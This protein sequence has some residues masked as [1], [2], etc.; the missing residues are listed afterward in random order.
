MI[1]NIMHWI[2][3]GLYQMIRE[4]K[5]TNW[6]FDHKYDISNKHYLL[7]WKWIS[8]S[9]QLTIIDG[10]FRINEIEQ[11]WKEREREGEKGERVYE[12]SWY[13]KLKF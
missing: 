1:S 11:W 2:I 12:H 10:N 7:S 8:F 6:Y 9:F 5:N 3:I 4:M 13:V